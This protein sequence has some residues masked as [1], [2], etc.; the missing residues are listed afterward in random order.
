[1]EAVWPA[2]LQRHVPGVLLVYLDLNHW[3][4]LSKAAVGHRDG[5]RYVDALA[6]CRAAREAGSAL[7][8]L[9]SVHYMEVAKIGRPKHREDLAAIM[10]EL[11]GFHTLLSG[12]AIQH[13]ERESALDRLVDA[14][15]SLP[16]PVA[17]V[18]W[19][20]GHAFGRR[21][22]LQIVG[23]PDAM[24][25]ARRRLGP[26]GLD[27]LLRGA[28]LT[29]ERMVLAGPRDAE[30]AK[31]LRA[32]GWQPDAAARIAKERAAEEAKQAGR[33]DADSRW[34]RG[35]TRDVISARELIIELE[36]LNES[37]ATRGERAKASLSGR[38]QMEALV[39]LM[40]S[41]EVAIELKTA[42]HRN[43]NTKWDSNAI[44]DIDAMSVAVPYCDIVVADKETHTILKR[45]NLGDRMDTE[46]FCQ[47]S[48]LADR[49]AA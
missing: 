25:E 35:R 1:M 16:D 7:F 11:S 20:V 29:F 40:P 5:V 3:V 44:F 19:G 42:Y 36:A 30:E 12:A 26:D 10:Q 23:A 48:E 17:L 49:L 21:G 2:G 46:V 37:L 43:A 6:A 39:H 15:P 13:I 27:E 22:R 28:E 9:S 32:R 14:R 34:R 18:G 4:G 8:P 31:T 33:F 38:S 41:L 24:E 45:T 47:P